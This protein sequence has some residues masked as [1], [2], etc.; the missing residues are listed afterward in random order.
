MTYSIYW[1]SHNELLREGVIFFDLITIAGLG[2]TMIFAQIVQYI[3]NCYAH[4]FITPF[5][6]HSS[7]PRESS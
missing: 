4:R 5:L 6:Q 2:M 1:L 3:D 7:R